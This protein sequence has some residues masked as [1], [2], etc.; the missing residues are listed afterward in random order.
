MITDCFYD[1]SLHVRFDA[2]LQEDMKTVNSGESLL[3]IANRE[4]FNLEVPTTDQLRGS[5]PYDISP[6]WDDILTYHHHYCGDNLYRLQK[7]ISKKLSK[8][9]KR[10]ISW[11]S[12]YSIFAPQKK[13]EKEFYSLLPKVRE[14]I[15]QFTPDIKR[16]HDWRLLLGMPHALYISNR[17]SP[18]GWVQLSQESKRFSEVTL[19]LQREIF[20]LKDYHLL[21]LLPEEEADP[22]LKLWGAHG[23]IFQLIDLIEFELNYKDTPILSDIPAPRWIEQALSRAKEEYK[24]CL[25]PDDISVLSHIALNRDLPERCKPLQVK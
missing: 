2:R 5:E 18:N 20:A 22:V 13:S 4:G 24:H 6:C 11:I 19:K 8:N 23:R 3:K 21:S 12:N 16:A 14:T 17:N 9:A 10:R 7:L 25:R 1:F 15:D